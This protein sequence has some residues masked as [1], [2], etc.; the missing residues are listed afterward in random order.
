MLMQL[1]LNEVHANINKLWIV[2]FTTFTFI[3]YVVY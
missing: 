3:M 2:H 1:F